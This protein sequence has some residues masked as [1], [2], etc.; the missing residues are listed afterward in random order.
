MVA[1]KFATRVA[2]FCTLTSPATCGHDA[3]KPPACMQLLCWVLANGAPSVLNSTPADAVLSLDMIVLL[4][5]FAFNA[6]SREIP[7]PSQPATLLTMM[8]LVTV[9][10]YHGEREPIPG[11]VTLLA[12]FGKLITSEPLTCCKRRPPPLPLSAALPMIRL[13]LITRPGPTPSLGP[14]EPTGVGTQSV[15]VVA[16]QPG[17]TSGVPMTRRPPPLVAIDGLVL[18]LNR[19]ELCSMSPP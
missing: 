18:W 9:A 6:S 14:T 11:N 5:M 12:P 17:S 2:L 3:V 13:A 10:E 4:M 8:L 7:A 15:S 19:I 16:P 1:G